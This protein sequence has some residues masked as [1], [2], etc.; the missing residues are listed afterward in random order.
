MALQ[1]WNV[2]RI[3][4][5]HDVTKEKTWFGTFRGIDRQSSLGLRRG[6]T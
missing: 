3:F 2:K 6:Q 4:G 5:H 1:A